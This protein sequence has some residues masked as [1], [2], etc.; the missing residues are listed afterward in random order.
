MARPETGKL[1]VKADPGKSKQI[2]VPP[3]PRLLRD[4]SS[5][6]GFM[7]WG[8]ETIGGGVGFG[9]LSVVARNVAGTS[10]VV[11]DDRDGRGI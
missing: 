5:D 2:G 10:G 11:T 9:R 4:W 7:R 1:G 8:V 3:P 6:A